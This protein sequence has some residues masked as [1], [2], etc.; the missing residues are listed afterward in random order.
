MNR[1]T[2]PDR[3]LNGINAL[4]K[5]GITTEIDLILGLPGDDHEGFKNTLKFIVD[6]NLSDDIQLFPLSI[7]P[8]TGFRRDAERLGI[9]YDKNPPYTVLSTG[10][11]REDEILNAFIE[12][13]KALEVSF[14]PMPD[15]DLSF[16]GKKD[17]PIERMPDVKVRLDDTY[18]YCKVWLHKNRTVEDLERVA[19]MV[20][21]PYQ[22]MVPPSVDDHGY[23]IRALSLFTEM[24]P[25]T[26][27][28]IVFFNP[29]HLPDV[30]R[31]L[32]TSRIDRPHYLDGHLRPL[33]FTG[34]NRSILFTVVTSGAGSKFSGPMQ[35]LLYWWQALSLP[36][37]EEINR[38][39][40]QG[41]DGILID[42]DI[43]LHH[44]QSFQ[45]KMAHNA[46]DFIHITFSGL[47]LNRRWLIKTMPD[48]YCPH[49]LPIS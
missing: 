27:C 6:N 10:G 40:S 38:L 25:H 13:E 28:E 4:K 5:R 32:E 42:S 1:K 2:D 29:P 48:D 49:I 12:A 26:P 8:G 35:R 34:G 18:L 22:L 21:Q 36:D 3:F 16:R 37:K 15:I 24:N 43:E 19:H 30:L 7:L 20:T 45:D 47:D 39:E 46:G 44:I 11:F 23:V 41:F 9:N 31:L 17:I 33:Y 14:Y